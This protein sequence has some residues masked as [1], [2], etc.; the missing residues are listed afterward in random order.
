MDHRD[1]V[2]DAGSAPHSETVSR[3]KLSIVAP[4]LNE[5]SVVG[6]FVDWCYEG[7][8]AAGVSGQI[9]IVDSSTDRSPEI[10]RAG[11]RNAERSVPRF[12]TCLHRRAVHIRGEYVL[13]G[14]CDLTY[15]FRQIHPFLERLD[16]GYDFVMG[17]RFKGYIEP[18]SMPWLHRCFGIPLTTKILNFMYAARYSDIHCG[19]RA[20]TLTA[21]ERLHLESQS[22]EYASE[23]VLKASRLKLKAAEVPV[24]FYKDRAGRI[25]HHKRAGWMSPWKA[26][27]SNLKAMFLY[28][29]DF[30]LLLPG[31][32]LFA[33]GLLLSV[34]LVC[35]PYAMLSLHF[36]ILAA[37]SHD[38]RLGGTDGGTGAVFLRFRSALA[39]A[40]GCMVGVRSGRCG[41]LLPRR[42]RVGSRRYAAL[43]MDRQWASAGRDFLFR[44]LRAVA[45]D[46]RFPDLCLHI[47]APHDPRATREDHAMTGTVVDASPRREAFGERNLTLVDRFGVYLSRRAIL[48][49]LPGRASLSVLTSAAA[50]GPI[51]F[52][53]AA[54]P[55]TRPG[56]RRGISPEVA[57]CPKLSFIETTVEEALPRLEPN[58]FD[59][60]LLISVL[61]HLRTP[62]SVLRQ[63]QRSPQ[64]GR[65]IANQC[66]DLVGKGFP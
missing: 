64:A 8:R 20:L 22:W 42:D 9:L 30:F 44:R 50:T 63:C 57:A 26:G 12:G 23:M 65:D 19:M 18:R 17:S 54:L 55:G 45:L 29:P 2:M 25:S 36:Q 56:D 38:G 59:V 24:R 52:A 28:A 53:A 4:C 14:D 40:A 49:S 41:R 34:S 51:Y 3:P 61:E 43:A 7:L 32:I 10:A 66:T 37:D 13:M 58:Q 5:E 47:A 1:E 15:D 39:E 62:L 11:G 35:G 16:E 46:S 48:R 31:L 21:L 60:V 27:W 6:E 33:V